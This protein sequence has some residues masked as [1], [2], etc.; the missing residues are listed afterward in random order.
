MQSVTSGSYRRLATA[1][2]RLS[3][4]CGIG[5]KHLKIS[6]T[7]K[8]GHLQANQKSIAARVQN[9]YHNARGPVYR[10]LC[11]SAFSALSPGPVRRL[12][13][14]GFVSAATMASRLLTCNKIIRPWHRMGADHT[15]SLR[16]LSTWTLLIGSEGTFMGSNNA[17]A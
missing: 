9:V 6:L 8:Y 12:T 10:G 15:Q 5:F 4:L 1:Y 17:A 13:S 11:G 16:F 14:T 7:A 3:V 2:R